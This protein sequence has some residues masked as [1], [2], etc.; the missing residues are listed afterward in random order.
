[1]YAW[2]YG[3]TIP[4]YSPPPLDKTKKVWYNVVVADNKRR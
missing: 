4:P 1:M 2:E 3:G